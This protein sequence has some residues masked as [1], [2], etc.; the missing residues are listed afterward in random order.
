MLTE[1]TIKRFKTIKEITLQLQR[2]NILIG[3]NNSGKSSILQALQFAVSVGQTLR[4]TAAEW[5]RGSMKRSIPASQLVYT[6]LRDI[7]SLVHNR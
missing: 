4:S 2:I 5:K 7:A 6:P 3:S 1:V